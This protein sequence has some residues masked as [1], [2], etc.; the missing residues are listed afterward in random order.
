MTVMQYD[1]QLLPL[2]LPEAATTCQLQM[3]PNY[4]CGREQ[5]AHI[6]KEQ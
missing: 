5:R 6:L 2:P 1:P 3:T 4:A